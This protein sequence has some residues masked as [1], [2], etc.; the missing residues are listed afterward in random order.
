MNRWTDCEAIL[1]AFRSHE[2]NGTCD[3]MYGPSTT[4][5]RNLALK[6]RKELKDAGEIINAY[7]KIP[8]KFDHQEE[9]GQTILADC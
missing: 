4:K 7:L 8:E 9:G 6:R 2:V 1:K 5:R 3:Y